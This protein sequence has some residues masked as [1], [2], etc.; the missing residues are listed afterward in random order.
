MDDISQSD[1]DSVDLK[2]K[3]HK[4]LADELTRIATRQLS[5]SNK[6]K[7]PLVTK[8]KTYQDLKAG[9][10]KKKLRVQ[11]NV[12]LP[13]F[14]G[15]LD[16][17]AAD[18]DEPIELKYKQKHPADYFKMQRIQAAWDLEKTKYTKEARWDFKARVDKSLNILHGR[19]ILKEYAFSDPKYTNVLDN[20]DPLYFHCQPQGGGLLENHLFAGEEAILRSESALKSS[21][22]YD[23]AQVKELIAAA[24][25]EE[26][27]S[28][29]TEWDRQKLQRFQVLGLDPSNNNYVG[30]KTFNLVEW[31]LTH[32]GKRWYLLFDPWT[33][34]WVRCEKLRDIYS[35]DLFPWVS[36]ATH[37]DNMVFWTPSYADVIYPVA[38]SIVTLFNQELTNREKRNMG[39]RAY[40][41]DMW[42]DV[43]KL[44]EAQYRADALVPFDSKNGSRKVSDGLY[45]FD[46]P[47][48]QGTIEL[49]GWT[50]Q[51]LQ[52]ETGISDISQGV[53]MNAAKKVNVAYMEQAGVAK[54]LGYKSQSYTEA[55][56]EIGVRYVQGLKDHMS[57]DMYIEILG[58][59]GIEPDV[60]SREDLDLKGEMGVEVIS[61]TSQK[62]ETQKKKQARIE[63][64]KLL[65]QDQNV[66]SEW[67]TAAILSDIGDYPESEIKMA[68]DTKNYAAKESVAKAHICIQELLAGGEPEMNYAADAVFLKVIFDYSMD[69]RN[70]LGKERFKKFALYIAKHTKLAQD[71]A[72]R[73][74][75][76]RGQQGKRAMMQQAIAGGKPVQGS[77][78]PPQPQ[79]QAQPG[80]QP[81][82]SPM[83]QP[84]PEMAQVQA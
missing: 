51:N 15:M 32:K 26:Y 19:S 23:K 5:L 29:A 17:L 79:G 46:T 7:E 38:D 74:G 40:D 9:N 22:V 43:A 11:F 62:A 71:N 34:I 49:L 37:E 57:K 24:S 10:V 21:S 13:V 3:G 73:S 77:Q 64:I 6:F 28:E 55:W 81:A 14:Q 72:Q 18:F 1:V 27:L 65:A 75:A 2:T 54:R 44:D 78:M 39:A 4:E 67:K 52:K 16:T 80:Q 45:R 33:S 31:V 66:N 56:G 50:M 20:T 30:E 47:E 41:K 82:P 69:H 70:K 36:W 59:M 63:A 68:L 84:Q 58:D 42:P 83:G 48:L 8:W 60:L 35:K 53:A 12:A 76:Q 25:S 61:S